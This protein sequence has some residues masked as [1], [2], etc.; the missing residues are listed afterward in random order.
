MVIDGKVS[1]N[2]DIE[3]NWEFMKALHRHRNVQ[4][5]FVDSVLKKELCKFS[6]SKKDYS[7]N[8]QVLRSLRHEI[9]HADHLHVRLRCPSNEKKC[10][11]QPD[12]PA[13]SGC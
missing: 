5:I 9:N 13:G 10:V 3:R 6:K 1:A 8:I 4:K 7:G 11:N 12:P 2:F